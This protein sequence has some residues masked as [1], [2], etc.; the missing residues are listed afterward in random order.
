[1]KKNIIKVTFVAAFAAIA[2]YNVYSSQKTD[3]MSDLFLNNVQALAN[4]EYVIGDPGTNWKEYR[5]LCSRTVGVDYI[6][7]GTKTTEYWADVC[8]YGSGWCL[9]PAGC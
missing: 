7:V 8:G 5:I 3:V 1:M 4:D 2:G 9:S 6:I